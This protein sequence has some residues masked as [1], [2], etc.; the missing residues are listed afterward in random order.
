MSCSGT[1]VEKEVGSYS[2]LGHRLQ[3]GETVM[4]PVFVFLES[5]GRFQE[6]L[7]WWP[8]V[9]CSM[10]RALKEKKTHLCSCL[11]G[12]WTSVHP[13]RTTAFLSHTTVKVAQPGLSAVDHWGPLLCLLLPSHST[14]P[15]CAARVTHWVTGHTAL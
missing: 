9:A 3:E 4:T 2:S 15:W 8:L 7:A 14:A 5:Q 13:C 10:F 6:E 12:R 1:P 11:S